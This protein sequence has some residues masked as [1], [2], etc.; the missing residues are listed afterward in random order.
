MIYSGEN[1]VLTS[2]IIAKTIL[3]PGGGGGGGGT[4]LY[5][6]YVSNKPPSGIAKLTAKLI[7]ECLEKRKGEDGKK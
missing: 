6:L 2:L 3:D 5:G 4:P 1:K 7:F